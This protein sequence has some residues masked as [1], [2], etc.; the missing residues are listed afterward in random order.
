MTHLHRRLHDIMTT[1]PRP[2]LRREKQ[3]GQ[4]P[5]QR[6]L[7]APVGSE[8]AEHLAFPHRE[9]NITKRLARAKN[10]AEA[11]RL[12]GVAHSADGAVSSVGVGAGTKST[13][14]SCAGDG[15]RST[16]TP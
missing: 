1:D 4:N 12:D 8:E 11:I 3:G 5:E 6:R 7:P 2:A 9:R 10:T 14:T 16:A 15:P 13:R